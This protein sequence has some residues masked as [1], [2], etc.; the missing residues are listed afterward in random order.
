MRKQKT[1]EAYLDGFQEITAYQAKTFY[2]GI[3][4]LFKLRG[5]MGEIQDLVILDSVD[6]G[7]YYR[8]TLKAEGIE[9][10]KEYELLNDHHLVTPL[11]M[12]LLV[13]SEAFDNAFF[14]DGDDLGPSYTVGAS[15]FKL[16]A[17]TASE[18]I[19]QLKGE[20]GSSAPGQIVSQAMTRG[21]RGVWSIEI[22]GNWERFSY[23]YLV[24]VN[25]FWN[26]ATDPYAKA[27]TPNSK[28]S[29]VINPEFIK[30][31]Q[32]KDKRA[33]LASY[34]DAVI[35][36]VHVRDL[37]VHANS[38]MKYKG[39]YL[40]FTE[41]GTK[42]SRGTAT[43]LDYILSLGVTHV[44]LL[45]VYDFGSVDEVNQFAFYNWGYDPV[46]YNIP[47]GSYAVDVHNPYSRILELKQLIAALHA[48]GLR[49][50]MDVVYNH[51]FNKDTSAFDRI[52]PDYYFRLGENGEISNGSFCSNDTDS[53]R[54]MMHKYIV[55]SVKMWATEYGF[56]G[57]RFDLMG[58]IDIAT[59][60]KLAEELHSMDSSIMVYGEGWN[61]P[62]LMEDSKKAAIINQSEMPRIAHFND[63]FFM[64]LR[65][66][67]LEDPTKPLGYLSGAEDL[68]DKVKNVIAGSVTTIGDMVPYFNEP[69]QAINYI[70]CHD[71]HTFWDK[72]SLCNSEDDEETRRKRQKLGTG[73]IFVSQGISFLHAG[74][75]F[76]RTK[77]GS[78]DSYMSPDS[79]NQLDWDRKDLFQNNVNYVRDMIALRKQLKPLRFNTKKEILE[80]VSLKALPNDVIIYSIDNIKDYCEYS[81]LLIMV[82]PNKTS[83]SLQLEEEYRI[84][85]DQN[86][87]N[88]T[89][90]VVH[91]AVIQPFELLVLAR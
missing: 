69:T 32:N 53:T 28:R 27:S 45:P 63:R 41:E 13:R 21:E 50:N 61:M 38:G 23:V 11:C 39:K 57:F 5:A 48:K 33:P 35:Y 34:T 14:Y 85:A 43:G 84:L 36:E 67:A 81:E 6:D 58:I 78:K 74:H 55:D 83:F 9:I 22:P 71:N 10:G 37:S 73:L 89:Q 68:A 18:V 30:I 1:L 59:M 54:K 70:E 66:H 49:V 7:E 17:P 40:A 86:G 4:V 24:K 62:T 56:D 52:V 90:G 42:T 75:E 44:Q 87:L 64:T 88:N 80:H 26:E 51:M 2:N 76:F 72:I 25:G 16:W 77:N 12:G 19:L 15:A 29:V 60:N 47:E 65:G 46:Q 8:Y 31:E 3:S 20:E 82:N 91:T 79:V